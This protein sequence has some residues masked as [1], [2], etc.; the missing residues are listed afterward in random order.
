[1]RLFDLRINK[2]TLYIAM[3]KAEGMEGSLLDYSSF[4]TKDNDIVCFLE[5]A[6]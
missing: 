1:L 6:N 4:F 5:I 3:L 2:E